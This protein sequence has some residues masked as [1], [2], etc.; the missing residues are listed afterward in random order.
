MVSGMFNYVFVAA[1]QAWAPAGGQ[2]L[3]S[4]QPAYYTAAVPTDP[5]IQT[6]PRAVT[7]RAAAPQAGAWQTTAGWQKVCLLLCYLSSTPLYYFRQA[8]LI[9]GS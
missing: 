9:T 4:T 7:P 5:R 8:W 2:D 6:T 1:A 3:Q